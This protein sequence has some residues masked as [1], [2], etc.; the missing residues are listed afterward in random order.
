MSM[1]DYKEKTLKQLKNELPGL[2]REQFE[3]RMRLGSGQL[4][5]THKVRELRRAIARIKTLI[6]QKEREGQHS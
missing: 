5:Q 1:Q 3:L 4:K 2:Y 6:T